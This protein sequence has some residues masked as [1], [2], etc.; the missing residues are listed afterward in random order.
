MR[1]FVLGRVFIESEKFPSELVSEKAAREKG[2]GRPPFWEMVFWWTRKPLATARAVIAGSLLPEDT[3]PGVFS[4]IVQLDRDNPHRYNPEIPR[5]YI[6]FFRG[7]S[8]LDPFAGFGNIPLEALRLGVGSVVAV[9][10]LPTAVIFLRAVLEYPRLFGR[11][12]VD[13]VG[14]WGEW[15]IERLRNDPDIKE[16]YD[17]DVAVYI[18]SWEIKCPY[19]G[20]YTPLVG[21]WWLARVRKG[22]KYSRLAYMRPVKQGDK[23]G[24]E[25]I[26]LNRKYGVLVAKARVSKTEIVVNGAVES[27]PEPNIEAR[28]N[29]AI[30]LYCH[31]VIKYIDP[32]TGKHY[33]ET[34]NLPTAIKNRV[35]PYVKYA[36]KQYNKLLEQYLQGKITLEQLRQAPARLRILVKVKTRGKEL[37]F[38]PATRED[39][40]KLWKA[41]EK[42]KQQYP[43]PDIPTEPIPEYET[44]TIWVVV[45]GFNKWF[46]LFN[47]R[48]LLT[49]TKLAKL[50]RET[51]KQVEKEKLEQG[52]SPEKAHK[53]AEAITTYLA[54]ALCKFAD[55]N[56]MMSGWQLSYLIAAHTL[57]MRGIAIVWNWGE[58]NPYSE[59]S[60]T[61]AA[62]V[63]RNIKH[64]L[65]YLVNAVS[66]DSSRVMVLQD[67]AT[68]LGRLGDEG[69]DV[70][71]TDPPYYDDV[72]Y[73]ELSDFYFVWLKRA[74]SAVENGKLKPWFHRDVL[75]RRVGALEVSVSTQ[76]ELFAKRE[77]SFNAN[78][79]L[80]E[81]GSSD[82][83]KLEEYA[84][85]RYRE[86]LASAFR[87][88]ASRLV[89]DGVLVTYYNHTSPDA[90]RDLLWAGWREAGLMVTAIWPL[91]TESPQAV[92]RRGK[93]RLDTSL[94]VVWRK[95]RSGGEAFAN[96]VFQ[97]A[98]EEAR[99]WARRIWDY[100]RGLDAFIAVMGRAYSVATRYDRI[101]FPEKR[102]WSKLV[103]TTRLGDLEEKIIKEIVF[104]AAGRGLIEFLS[105]EYNAYI[106]S[107]DAIA[108]ILFKLMYAGAVTEK[109][110]RVS[111]M[112]ILSLASGSPVK[113]FITKKIVE[114]RG[115]GKKKRYVLLEPRSTKP[116][117]FE[118][119]LRRK[120]LDPLLPRATTS[121]D[122]LHLL[123][124]YALTMGRDQFRDKLDKLRKKIR[125]DFI[126]E[127]IGI[128]KILA[129]VLS[130][131]EPERQAITRILEY[132]GIDIPPSKPKHR[133]LL[134]FT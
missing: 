28:K 131:D 100:H 116:R 54:I 32:E 105:E 39:T 115:K 118:A 25:V 47:P 119:F 123:E 101:V 109:K 96:E 62:M 128:A 82:H 120:N 76:W 99:D 4:R 8:L 130:E 93:L 9:E 61:F 2:P 85:Q 59:Y 102:N 88:M 10:L 103:V 94:I 14:K 132:L 134:E 43:Y 63:E 45:Y 31:N 46:K 50:I 7:R 34:K 19:C 71:V 18:G 69:F 112:I 29:Q 27:I 89:E 11:E 51:G 79:F 3:P 12:I 104:P 68:V 125:A 126:D 117:E 44:R 70:I 1:W 20:R 97:Q 84:L 42:I 127:A 60:G 52:W 22:D 48:Q 72:P 56:S 90:W 17:R 13:D 122:V 53:Y 80:D 21:N 5:D 133:S 129:H 65:S 35:E 95:R 86:L 16:L 91:L 64:S 92:T 38:Q 6:E 106:R 124:Y 107:S 81:V 57:A 78:R 33:L 121:I 73:T 113:S 58:Y 23:I 75:F 55:Y 83:K 41:L 111:D 26:D 15:I 49:L 98:L 66:G 67:D 77:I 30:C 110:L 114:E 37:E 40:E 87:S 74:L 24:I 36:L 108:Y